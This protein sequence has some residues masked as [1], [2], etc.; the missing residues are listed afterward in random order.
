MKLTIT[1]TE[2]QEI[3]VTFPLYKKHHSYFCKATSENDWV[4]VLPLINSISID[5]PANPGNVI[6]NGEDITED[7]FNDAFIE[8][9]NKIKSHKPQYSAI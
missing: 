5:S 9:F 6:L 2:T 3:E 4:T 8:V 1:K 7:Q